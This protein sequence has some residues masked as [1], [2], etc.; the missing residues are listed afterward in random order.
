MAKYQI[1][2]SEIHKLLEKSET[3]GYHIFFFHSVQSFEQGYSCNS[4]ALPLHDINNTK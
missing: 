4:E 2:K 1:T 3:W